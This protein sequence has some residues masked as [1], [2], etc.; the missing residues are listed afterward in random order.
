MFELGLEDIGVEP[1]L[2]VGS[3]RDKLEGVGV[4]GH[5]VR[6]VGAG[7][8]MLL[9]KWES[10]PWKREVYNSKQGR[11]T[12]I[13]EQRRE[14]RGEAASQRCEITLQTI[15]RDTIHQ[16]VS[17][18]TTLGNVRLEWLEEYEHV[19]KVDLVMR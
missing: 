8:Y 15:N 12:R 13:D 3:K 10:D 14:L 7:L 19:Q 17:T 5:V 2:E 11:E 9:I 1:K 16:R 18:R 6:L 4:L